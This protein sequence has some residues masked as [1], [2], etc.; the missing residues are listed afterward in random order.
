MTM[1]KTEAMAALGTVGDAQ[2][3]LAR[4]AN[5]P[6]WRHAAFGGLMGML[7]LAQGVETPLNF[8]LLAL[9]ALAGA[10]IFISDRRRMGMFVNGYRKGATR[11]M[12]FTLLGAMLVIGWGELAAKENGLSLATRIAL[13]LIA[14]AL[15]TAMSVQWQRIF[16]RELGV[17]G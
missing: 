12:T 4:A 15:A 6:T 14:A 2:A 3:A 8:A 7:V 17:E 13:A 9:A 1:D 16:R 10:L 11:P 5:C